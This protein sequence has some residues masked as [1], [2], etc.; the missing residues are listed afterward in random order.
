[1]RVIVLRVPY[2][3]LVHVCGGVLE[4]P[5]VAAEDDE[6]DLAVAQDAQLVR[7]LHHAKLA[8]VERN[9]KKKGVSF[10]LMYY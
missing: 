2:E 9:L 1:M 7:L 5:V 6:G 8:L 3:D 4:Q 10:K